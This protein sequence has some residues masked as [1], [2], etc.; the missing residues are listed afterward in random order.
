[1]RSGPRKPR[2]YVTKEDLMKAQKDESNCA[3][4]SNKRP[5]C[6]GMYNNY[7]YFKQ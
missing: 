6:A 4:P 5:H 2:I 3:V 7:A 1:M